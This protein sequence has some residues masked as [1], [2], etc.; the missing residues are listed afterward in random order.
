MRHTIAGRVCLDC[1]R[2]LETGET[3]NCR[4][5]V[6]GVT[7]DGLRARCP[8]F[9]HRSSYQGR[10]YLTCGELKTV[11]PGCDQRNE[12][13]RRYCCGLYELCKKYQT[14]KGEPKSNA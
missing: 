8:C 14:M 5:P 7:R 2:P 6:R 9:Q 12:Q 1:G 4:Q 3:C 11:Y 10:Y 13:Y